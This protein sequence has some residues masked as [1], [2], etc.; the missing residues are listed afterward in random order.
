[1]GNIILVATQKATRAHGTLRHQ[2]NML[3]F[4]IGQEI[5]NTDHLAWEGREISWS[6]VILV[7]GLW[8][9]FLN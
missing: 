7:F 8:S 1:L 4:I 5:W 2:M 9:F 3:D 6:L